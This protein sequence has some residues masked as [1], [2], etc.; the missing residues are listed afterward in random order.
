MSSD[1]WF[2]FNLQ[3][4]KFGSQR[5]L[6]GEWCVVLGA[7]ESE[8]CFHPHPESGGVAF[9]ISEMWCENIESE[10]VLKARLCFIAFEFAMYLWIN[11]QFE[12]STLESQSRVILVG[13]WRSQVHSASDPVGSTR[14][15][16]IS[17]PFCEGSANSCRD[18]PEIHRRR[19][20][21]PAPLRPGYRS[22]C[23]CWNFGIESGSN[24][25]RPAN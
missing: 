15:C 12:E 7:L 17:K 13:S 6:C 14:I 16:S 18:D 2:E 1:S 4:K 11:L 22:I 19:A 10:G 23:L 25:M 20:L 5:G 24:K 21:H 8:Q 3:C 9:R